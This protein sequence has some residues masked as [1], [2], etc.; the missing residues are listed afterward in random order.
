MI[1]LELLFCLSVF[2]LMYLQSG[3]VVCTTFLN[4]PPESGQ[5][6]PPFTTSLHLSIHTRCMLVDQLR[7]VGNY[8][9]FVDPRDLFSIPSCCLSQ[10]SNIPAVQSGRCLFNRCA[11]SHG[12]S[13]FYQ[14]CDYRSAGGFV[15][16]PA[17]NSRKYREVRSSTGQI[18][19]RVHSETRQ[20]LPN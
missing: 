11:C 6:F 5:L 1:V 2:S 4:N 14:Y 16:R 10:P 18:P 9:S 17:I 20:L 12:L 15:V 13:A 3:I 19:V 8:H 7:L